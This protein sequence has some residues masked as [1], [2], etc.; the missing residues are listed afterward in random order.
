MGDGSS[1]G[2]VRVFDNPA[3]PST[4]IDIIPLHRLILRSTFVDIIPLHVT[5][6]ILLHHPVTR[7]VLYSTRFAVIEIAHERTVSPS[8]AGCAL[9]FCIRFQWE[10][11]EQLRNRIVFFAEEK[12]SAV[13]F[14]VE[15]LVHKISSAVMTVL[16]ANG[17][18][19]MRG[20]G[21]FEAP[22][23]LA[24]VASIGAVNAIHALLKSNGPSPSVNAFN[25][26][27]M[28]SNS[29]YLASIGFYFLLW[30]RHIEA[31]TYC[32]KGSLLSAGV[33]AS[34]VEKIVTAAVEVWTSV[35]LDVDER[36]VP[37]F[38]N[39]KTITTRMAAF[40]STINFM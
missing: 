37:R 35:G 38:Y 24:D 13:I 22:V 29:E 20:N 9:Y 25:V 6:F 7:Y 34:I 1:H 14:S 17:V 32:P 23:T 19:V 27:V 3:T 5:F 8:P 31:H 26:A 30:L 36:G 28:T 40:S 4:F 12:N 39:K 18:G 10:L 2:L 16:A 21:L 15:S 11:S 33:S